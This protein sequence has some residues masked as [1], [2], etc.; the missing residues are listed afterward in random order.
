MRGERPIGSRRSRR[1]A[2]PLR[3]PCCHRRLGRRFRVGLPPESKSAMSAVG[4]DA[5]PNGALSSPT[6]ATQEPVSVSQAVRLRCRLSAAPGVR[7][8]TLGTD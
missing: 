2:L 7:S 5:S 4:S 1:G 6:Y 3:P 8:S